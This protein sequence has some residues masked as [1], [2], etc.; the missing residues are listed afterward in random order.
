[1]GTPRGI[2]VSIEDRFLVVLRKNAFRGPYPAKEPERMPPGCH[3]YAVLSQCDTNY[4]NAPSHVQYMGFAKDLPGRH[5]RHE[6]TEARDELAVFSL[7]DVLAGLDEDYRGEF[8]ALSEEDR[9]DLLKQAERILLYLFERVMGNLPIRNTRKERP[10][11]RVAFVTEC[12]LRLAGR[13]ERALHEGRSHAPPEPRRGAQGISERTL[14]DQPARTRGQRADG[15]QWAERAIEA[16]NEALGPLKWHAE[17][18]KTGTLHTGRRS[19]RYVVR[20]WAHKDFARPRYRRRGWRAGQGGAGW[21][22][23]DQKILSDSFL[24]AAVEMVRSEWA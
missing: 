24:R 14:P 17:R 16:L 15:Y 13:D 5:R 2:D 7:A 3:I 20:V 18:R 22:N 11:L 4:H 1:M 9:T 10:D 8:A 12:V 6:H 19:G 23:F 21:E